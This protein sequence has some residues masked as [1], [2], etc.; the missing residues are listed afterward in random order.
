[1]AT[2]SNEDQQQSLQ[3]QDSTVKFCPI[4]GST[5][6]QQDYLNGKWWFCDD[7]ECGFFEPV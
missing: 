1:M 2:Q 3:Q 4:C 6:H 5:M 7:E